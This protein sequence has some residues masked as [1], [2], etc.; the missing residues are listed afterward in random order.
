M[1]KSHVEQDAAAGGGQFRELRLRDGSVVIVSVA[2]RKFVDNSNKRYGYMQFKTQGKTV[3]KYIGR[4]T[5]NSHDESLRLG[6]DLIHTRKL[7]ESFGWRWVTKR[8][9]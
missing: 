8:K 3:T 4:V 1:R 5:A 2:A 7:A 9:A 6:W